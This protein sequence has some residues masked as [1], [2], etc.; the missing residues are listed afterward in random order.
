MV[1]LFNP[2]GAARHD[3]VTIEAALPLQW[4]QGVQLRDGNGPIEFQTIASETRAD[5]SLKSL[6]LLVPADVPPLGYKTLALMP[7][8]PP[9]VVAP[10]MLTATPLRL[11]GPFYVVELDGKHG[12]IRRIF[13]KQL[14]REMLATGEVFGNELWSPENPRES[15]TH[16]T[17][18]VRVVETGPLRATVVVRST[19]GH[20]PYECAI[21]LYRDLKRIDFKLA[22]DY[23][24]GFAFG[25]FGKSGTGLFVHFPTALDGKMF[26]NQPFG[27]YETAAAK[28][29]TGDFA[30]LDQ[31]G[32]G[33]AIIH[34]NTPCVFRDG[35]VLRLILSQGQPLVVGRQNYEYSLV[36]YA[37]DVHHA[38]VYGTAQAINTPLRVFW[39]PA[40]ASPRAQD[41][42]MA[43][44]RPDVK[45]SALL[46]AGSTIQARF[47]ETAGQAVRTTVRLPFPLTDCMQIK[48]NGEKV[49]TLAGDGDQVKLDFRPWEIVTLSV[50][51]P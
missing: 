27:I 29:V 50:A 28:Q 13:D 15:S 41:S 3:L 22:V 20:L 11:E 48:L 37:H 32:F 8:A 21:S 17:A 7:A 12:G 9:A 46:M 36:S 1:C 16:S 10:S 25:Q 4:A 34:R 26:I 19:I 49:R 31:N 47:F 23:G 18:D 43:I 14:S 42:F 51:N 24:S 45:L 2:L 39:P 40:G 44:D 33:L 6:K 35:R 5:G 30:A 38:D